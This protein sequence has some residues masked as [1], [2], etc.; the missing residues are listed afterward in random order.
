M[1]QVKSQEIPA[2]FTEPQF[3]QELLER[4]ARD[5]GAV[6]AVIYSDT[7]DESVP[8]YI[9]MMRFNAKTLAEH[10]K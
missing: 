10:L 8:T 7:L 4:A 2:V 9:E 3:R 5:A 6:L 1:E